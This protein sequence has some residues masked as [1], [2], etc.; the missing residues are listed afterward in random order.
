MDVKSFGKLYGEKVRPESKKSTWL[1]K[2]IINH[3]IS[4]AND[5]IVPG[6]F[7]I[8]IMKRYIIAVLVV[9]IGI[10]G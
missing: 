9:I 2:N 8:D 10:G 1:T 5:I 7:E 4:A 3:L 6:L